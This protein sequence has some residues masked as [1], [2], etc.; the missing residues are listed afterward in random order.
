MIKLMRNTNSKIIE[1][2]ALENIK[3]IIPE[4]IQG[5]IFLTGKI[6]MGRAAARKA[7]PGRVAPAV[8]K[9]EHAP[10]KSAKTTG[11]IAKKKPVKPQKPEKKREIAKKTTPARKKI[12]EKTTQARK[13]APKMKKM[14]SRRDK[15]VAKKRGPKASSKSTSIA[16]RKPKT[17]VQVVKKRRKTRTYSNRSKLSNF[18]VGDVV[19]FRRVRDWN[20][21]S[22]FFTIRGTVVGKGKD[23]QNGVNFIEVKFETQ[24]PSGTTTTEIR[25]FMV[26]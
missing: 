25:R 6:C 21:Q 10:K 19:E 20:N 17:P 8:S 13:K 2:M 23:P 1:G 11:K 24:T 14:V 3:L 12:S 4:R 5:L 9:R 15:A 26:K 22:H 18:I 7:K 16:V